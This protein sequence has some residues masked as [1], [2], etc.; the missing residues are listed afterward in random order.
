MMIDLAEKYGPTA[1]AIIGGSLSFVATLLIETSTVSANLIATT[2]MTF[3]IVLA[4]FS[5]TQRNMLISIRRTR[6]IDRAIDINQIERVLSYL[7]KSS[8]VGLVLALYSFAG[9]FIDDH[10]VVLRAWIAGLGAL[11]FFAIAHLARNEIIMSL[12]LKRI[13]A[14]R[15]N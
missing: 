12:I 7:T 14:K 3:G 1:F 5:G 13:M 9:F 11:V 10:L 6:V 2:T 4:G 15:S 8:Y